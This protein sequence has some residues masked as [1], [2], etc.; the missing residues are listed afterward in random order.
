VAEPRPEAALIHLGIVAE[1]VW[2]RSFFRVYHSAVVELASAGEVKLRKLALLLAVLAL[3]A[4]PSVADAQGKGKKRAAAK[5]AAAKMDPN[6][7]GRRL[8]GEAFHQIIVPFESMA[9]ASAQPAA[10]PAKKAK[11]AGKKAKKKMG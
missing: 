4:A 9:K 5:P 1:L 6:E 11:K 8:V 10:K 2:S 3:A 7:P